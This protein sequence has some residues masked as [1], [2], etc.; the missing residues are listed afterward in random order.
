MRIRVE[1]IPDEGL[2]V[3]FEENLSAGEVRLASPARAR[4]RVEKIDPEVTVSGTV[5][6]DV[7][8]ECSRCLNPFVGRLDVPV[9][10]VYHPIE[11]AGGESH[12]LKTDEMDMGFYSGGEIDLGELLKE[13]IVLNLDMKPLCAETCKG[14]CPA[15][16]ADR[17][18]ADCNCSERETDP[19]LEALKKLLEK[20]KE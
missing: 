20:G 4:F 18:T 10:V 15:C 12:E 3:E 8:Y 9:E 13:Q 1:D 19:R 11:E 16:G 17:N 7:E 6:A 5:A 2:D 14:I